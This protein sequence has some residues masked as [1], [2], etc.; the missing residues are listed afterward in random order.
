MFTAP[1]IYDGTWV[2]TVIMRVSKGFRLD[3]PSCYRLKRK[4]SEQ[5][6]AVHFEVSC[7]TSVR[8]SNKRDQSLSSVVATLHGLP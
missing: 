2:G 7:N 1:Y 3:K 8:T 4:E 5:C 6:S